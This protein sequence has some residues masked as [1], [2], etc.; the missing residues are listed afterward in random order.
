MCPSEQPSLL[1]LKCHYDGSQ[2]DTP[3]GGLDAWALSLYAYLLLTEY[4]EINKG[5]EI[6]HCFIFYFK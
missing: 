3:F 2:P 1:E 4:G 6:I 5:D